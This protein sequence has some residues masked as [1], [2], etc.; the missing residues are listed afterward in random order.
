MRCAIY[1]KSTFYLLTY[2]YLIFAGIG[3]SHW[4]R[5]LWVKGARATSEPHSS[6]IGLYVVA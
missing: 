5:Q 4:R 3:A 2:F 1:R 6:H